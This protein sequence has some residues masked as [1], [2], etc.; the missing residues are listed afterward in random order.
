VALKAGI[1]RPYAGRYRKS[2]ALPR[3]LVARRAIGLRVL[4]VV[5][6]HREIL[7]ARET[8]QCS[9]LRISVT[10]RAD[11]SA[12]S[13]RKLLLMATNAGRVSAFAGKTDLTGI[14]IPPVA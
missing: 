4:C 6:P 12:A 1:V 7:Q 5:K 10:D 11:L 9:V 2:N 3:R 14:V 13:H 8:L